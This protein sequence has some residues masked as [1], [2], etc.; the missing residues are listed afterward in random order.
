M[1]D[2][3][4]CRAAVDRDLGAILDRLGGLDEADWTLPVRCAGWTVADLAG[5]MVAASSGQA[6]GLRKAVEGSVEPTS[7][8][9]RAVGDGTELVAGLARGRDGLLAALDSLTPDVL[10]GLVPLP[11]GLVPVPVAVQIVALEYGFHRNDLEWALGGAGPLEPDIAG[12]LLE[13]SPGLLPMFA[14]GS[15]VAAAGDAPGTEVGYNLRAGDFACTILHR[16]G[17]WQVVDDPG[18]AT[19]DVLADSPSA[20]ALFIMGRIG[21]DHPTLKI[22]GDQAAAADFKRYFPGP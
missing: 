17:A 5:H 15:Q 11:F 8:P 10:E 18:A 21:A 1:F 14:D 6:E 13:V 12:T 20:L 3:T 4:T 16:D 19:C 9:A 22:T 2:L 7:L